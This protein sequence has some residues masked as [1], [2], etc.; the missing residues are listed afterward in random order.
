MAHQSRHWIWW[1]AL[2][3]SRKLGDPGPDDDMDKLLEEM[4]LLQDKIDALLRAGKPT[5]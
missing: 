1:T 4:G 5:G 2:I 3:Q